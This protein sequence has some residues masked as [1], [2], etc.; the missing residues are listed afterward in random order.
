MRNKFKVGDRVLC[1]MAYDANP[2]VRNQKG[3][4]R[5]IEKGT[6]SAQHALYGVEFDVDVNG[7]ELETSSRFIKPNTKRH[8]GWWVPTTHLKKVTREK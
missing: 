1:T 4:V 2:S 3:T 7:H 5:A 6:R 8:H